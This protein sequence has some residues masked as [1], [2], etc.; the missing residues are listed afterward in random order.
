MSAT[1]A[2]RKV[3]KLANKRNL[4]LVGIATVCLWAVSV[5]PVTSLP[6]L[7]QN[8]AQVP[9]RS[10]SAQEQREEKAPTELLTLA[11]TTMCKLFF[12]GK[13][14]KEGVFDFCGEEVTYSGD[15]KAD[16]S[17]KLFFNYLR[18]YLSACGIR[19]KEKREE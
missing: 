18:D 16:E 8:V 17:A 2:K 5:L 13:S 10:E 14:G 11:D 12:T 1:S 9:P 6:L 7:S 3:I 15:L 19:T 4:S